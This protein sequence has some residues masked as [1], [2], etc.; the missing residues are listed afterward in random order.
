MQA[1]GPDPRLTKTDRLYSAEFI[2]RNKR[3]WQRA[4]RCMAFL[5]G[6]LAGVAT[7]TLLALLR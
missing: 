5:L 3:D 4:D 2:A 6:W 1:R 7:I